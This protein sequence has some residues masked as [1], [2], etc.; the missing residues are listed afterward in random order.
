MS[1]G[2]KG[3]K[4]KKKGSKGGI[5]IVGQKEAYMDGY[6]NDT[7]GD[8]GYKSEGTGFQGKGV[9]MGGASAV[10]SRASIKGKGSVPISKP[11]VSKQVS[12]K[13]GKK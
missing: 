10:S 11:V 7:W 8:Y 13:N 2:T 1:E 4:K 3:S 9:S 12:K 5:R 6:V